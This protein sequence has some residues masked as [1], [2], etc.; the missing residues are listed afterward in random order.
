MNTGD[1][2]FCVA[3]RRAQGLYLLVTSK[4]VLAIGACHIKERQRGQRLG[5]GG[6]NPRK[7]ASAAGSYAC[8]YPIRSERM[9]LISVPYTTHKLWWHTQ[10]YLRV[11]LKNFKLT[12][13]KALIN[14]VHI[15]V[16]AALTVRRPAAL[17][18]HP[19]HHQTHDVSSTF[20]SN[21]CTLSDRI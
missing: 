2:R 1:G 15:K 12:W 13:A 14:S 18:L 10:I 21:G 11:Q 5:V 8:R 17:V 16:F 7:L 6:I 19:H 20:N 3:D 9:L 4:S